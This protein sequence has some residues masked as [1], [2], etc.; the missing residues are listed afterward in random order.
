MT[1]DGV[2]VDSGKLP[3]LNTAPGESESV[4]LPHPEPALEPGQECHLTVRFLSA[5]ATPWCDANHE[6]AWEQIPVARR[7]GSPRPPK[8]SG[9]SALRL[10][11]SDD[12][13]RVVGDGF[14]VAASR[15]IGALASFRLRETEL[16]VAGPRLNAWRAATDND[17]VKGWTG[18]ESKPLGRW[19]AAG[20]NEMRLE[21][22]ECAARRMRDGAVVIQIRTQ[23]VASG[24]KIGHTHTYTIHPDGG[25]DVENTFLCAKSLP[26]LP[27]LGVTM[28]L[29]PELEHLQWFGRGP[30]ESYSDRKRGTAVGL[31]SGTVADQYVPYILPQEHGNKTDVRW[32]NLETADGEGLA[33]SAVGRLMECSASHFTA[34]DLFAAKHTIDLAPRAEVIVNLDYA[35]RGLGTA[36]CGPDTL[37]PY[38]IPPATY[39]LNYRIQP[40]VA[41]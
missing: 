15:K 12:E 37:E 36:S 22:V 40:I 41:G 3:V 38:R 31:Y 2:G 6:V 7:K 5:K 27:R 30:H 34:A 28:T 16:L 18:Q 29:K 14:S 4:E 19:L 39:K 10:V 23:G 8:T 25:I 11:E 9:R 17:G 21:P 1:I 33:F 20:L 13:I 24:G 35:Q 32:M 26:D